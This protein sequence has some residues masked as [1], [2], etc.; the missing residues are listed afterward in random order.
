MNNRPFKVAVSGAHSTGKSMFLTSVRAK[1]ES[2]GARVESVHCNAVDALGRGFPILAEHTFGSTAWLM[3]RA[4]ELEEEAALKADVVLVDRPICDALGYLLAALRHTGRA[5]KAGS[6][7]R[8]RTI[9]EAWVGE[10]DVMFLTR[11]DPVIPL[12]PGRDQDTAFRL[13]AARA[14]AEVVDQLF[15]KRF[16][17][18]KDSSDKAL[19]LVIST[20]EGRQ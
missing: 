20:V 5:L 3:A 11:L 12:G 4:M 10:Y 14:I 8:L 7:E 9:C 17:L 6:Y 15:P 18:D 16:V 19:A 2:R 1:L 13:E